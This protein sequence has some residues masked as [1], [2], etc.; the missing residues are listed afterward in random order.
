MTTLLTER[1]KTSKGHI[2]RTR[3][4]RSKFLLPSDLCLSEMLIVCFSLVLFISKLFGGVWQE[5]PCNIS[6]ASKKAHCLYNVEVGAA[7]ATERVAFF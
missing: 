3:Q 1:H 5:F 2:L 7:V 6:W 4:V